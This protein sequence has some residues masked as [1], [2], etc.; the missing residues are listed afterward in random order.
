MPSFNPVVD[1]TESIAEKYTLWAESARPQLVRLAVSITADPAEAE[2]IVQDVLLRLWRNNKF[3]TADDA[4]KYART[5]VIHACRDRGRRARRDNH[6]AMQLQQIYEQS[7][8][9]STLVDDLS[10][11]VWVAFKG[12]KR[13]DCEV[14]AL[15]YVLDLPDDEIAQVLGCRRNTVRARA[16]RALRR[17]SQNIEASR[18]SDET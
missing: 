11:D 17:L 1:S 7:L 10:V 9:A 13:S 6:R 16:A 14:L 5:S 4:D 12:L 2:D 8:R 15:R 3:E 18:D